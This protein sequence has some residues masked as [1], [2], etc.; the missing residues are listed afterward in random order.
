L[1]EDIVVRKAESSK[2][3]LDGGCD[4]IGPAEVNGNQ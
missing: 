4:T 1:V 2:L 3:L